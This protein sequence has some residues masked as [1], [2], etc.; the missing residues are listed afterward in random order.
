MT[1]AVLTRAV[2]EP[3]TAAAF[4][5]HFPR[6]ASTPFVLGL[7][8]VACHEAVAGELEDGQVTVGT[9]VALE[10]LLPSPVGAV[11][12]AR[13]ELTERD[14]ARL[15]FKVDVFD[16]DALCASVEHHRAVVRAERI[17][18]KLAAR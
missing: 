16:G 14:G 15:R 2:C 8:E 4:G 13:A 17:A 18:A 7:A 10:H 6:A 1:S 9:Y 11:L 3:D 5:E 12:T